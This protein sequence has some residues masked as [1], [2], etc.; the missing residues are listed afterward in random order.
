MPSRSSRA[1]PSTAC[2]A[3][4]WACRDSGSSAASTFI[5]NGSVSPKRLA[6]RRA[7][8]SLGVIAD[9]LQQRMLAGVRLQP[10]RVA[11]V[12]AEP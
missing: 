8:L 2:S 9:G 5:K 4:G 11:R 6:H 7:Q 12:R 10:R 1:K 3:L